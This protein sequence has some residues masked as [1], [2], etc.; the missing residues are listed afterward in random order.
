LRL[1]SEGPL[2]LYACSLLDFCVFDLLLC[3]TWRMSN[4]YCRAGEKASFTHTVYIYMVEIYRFIYRDSGFCTQRWWLL[5]FLRALRQHSSTLFTRL[6]LFC[7][8]FSLML[9]FPATPQYLGLSSLLSA[10]AAAA[11]VFTN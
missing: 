5:G 1:W 2:E 8:N 6:L 7:L 9:V 10:S 3:S 4:N 11:A